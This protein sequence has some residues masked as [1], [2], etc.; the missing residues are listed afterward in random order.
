MFNAKSTFINAGCNFILLKWTLM[1]WWLMGHN[2]SFVTL[3]YCNWYFIVR[4]Q[5]INVVCLLIYYAKR[6]KHHSTYA[7]MGYT[8]SDLQQL[9]VW[10]NRTCYHNILYFLST[11]NVIHGTYTVRFHHMYCTQRTGCDDDNDANFLSIQ[12]CN[13]YCFFHMDNR[14]VIFKCNIKSA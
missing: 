14:M 12:N 2:F 3:H 4:N 11:R 9:K 1:I 7:D 10:Q 6:N 8:N 13:F 5:Q